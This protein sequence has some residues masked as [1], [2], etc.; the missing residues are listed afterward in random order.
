MPRHDFEHAF[1]RN[2]HRALVK[3]ARADVLLA[4]R[5][6]LLAERGHSHGQIAAGLGAFHV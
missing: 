4:L 3:D 2:L 5:V 6:R 1:V